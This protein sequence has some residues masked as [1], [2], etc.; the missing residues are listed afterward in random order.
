MGLLS[1]DFAKDKQ[2]ESDNSDASTSAT[3]REEMPEWTASHCVFDSSEHENAEDNLAYMEK[4]F[5]FVTPKE[6]SLCDVEGLLTYLAEKV[7]VRHACLTCDSY[8]YNTSEVQKHMKETAH[9][10]ITSEDGSVIEEYSEFYELEDEEN[11]LEE[12]SDEQGRHALAD[13]RGKDGRSVLSE[14]VS[15]AVGDKASDVVRKQAKAVVSKQAKNM[16]RRHAVG[17]AGRAAVGV[18]GGPAVAVVGGTVLTVLTAKAVY[19][20]SGK[21]IEAVKEA[22]EARGEDGLAVT[23]DAKA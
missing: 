13:C 4:E 19:D 8:F 9:F 18:V 1:L 21:A 22:R 11:I 7:G 16:V 15:D 2:V 6:A 14:K 12:T 10:R 3:H 5:G 23:E 17:I 20:A